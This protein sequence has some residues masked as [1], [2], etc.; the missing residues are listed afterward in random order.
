MFSNCECFLFR[1]T[2]KKITSICLPESSGLLCNFVWS[3]SRSIK[4]FRSLWLDILPS[5]EQ[6]TH[7]YITFN[8]LIK[9][10]YR[11]VIWLWHAWDIYTDTVQLLCVRNLDFSGLRSDLK[12]LRLHASDPYGTFNSISLAFLAR[13]AGI[14]GRQAVRRRSVPPR[15]R[16]NGRYCSCL[17]VRGILEFY[18][19]MTD[20]KIL[21]Q[22]RNRFVICRNPGEHKSILLRRFRCSSYF[23]FESSVILSRGSFEN[24][25]FDSE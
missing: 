9:S 21:V 15:L 8:P 17:D 13:M 5:R 19:V 24:K 11:L 3:W 6:M 14:L 10:D 23:I 2:K 7:I 12:F 25:I 16:E 20:V 1:V 22:V 18:R 4:A